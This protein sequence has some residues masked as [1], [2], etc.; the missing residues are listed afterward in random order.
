[1]R[2]RQLGDTGIQVSVVALGTWAFGGLD[3]GRVFDADSIKAV[4]RSLDLGVTLIDTAPIYG[5]GRAEE[6]LGVA[7]EGVRAGVVV[8]TKCGPQEVRPGMVRMDLSREGIRSQCI[9]SLRRLKTDW[10]DLLQVHWS[11][12]AWPVEDAIVALQELRQE[13]LIRAFGVSNYSAD[14]IT[15]ALSVGKVDSLQPPYNLFRREI[16]ESVLPLC[17]ENN[18]GV[19]AYEP[20]ARGLLTGK[21]DEKAKFEPG[22]VRARDRRFRHENLP[23]YLQAV[24]RVAMIAHREGMTP[25]QAAIAWVLAQPGITSAICGAKTA[26]QVVE[27]AR[28]ADLE[29]DGDTLARLT[30]V[31]LPDMV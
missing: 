17:R 31:S 28:A 24:R 20:L 3:W 18:I 29:P 16:E 9:E 11:D 12:P 14:E 27:N 21:F 8:A 10:I 30:A 19:I 23:R 1:M 4:R 6:V 22:D 13:G 5:N 15:R 25:A 26:T 2:Y 7:L